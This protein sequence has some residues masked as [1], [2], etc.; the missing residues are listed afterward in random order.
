MG[1]DR[2]REGVGKEGM[3]RKG[4]KLWVIDRER[5]RKK[6]VKKERKIYIYIYIYIERERERENPPFF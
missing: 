4:E 3:W 6:E 2:I 5:N 1:A